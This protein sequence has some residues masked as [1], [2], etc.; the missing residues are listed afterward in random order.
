MGKHLITVCMETWQRSMSQFHSLLTSCCLP[1]EHGSDTGSTSWA[2]E[3]QHLRSRE[4]SR[5]CLW[6]RWRNEHLCL[7]LLC[8]V[9]EIFCP[10]KQF[11]K[12]KYRPSF[13]LQRLLIMM[14]QSNLGS[15][16]MFQEQ[17]TI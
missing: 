7:L 2:Q 13:L 10:F 12:A 1:G 14:R 8:Q 9:Q 16:L 4:A 15:N 11:T 3:E 5:Y 17:I 6:V